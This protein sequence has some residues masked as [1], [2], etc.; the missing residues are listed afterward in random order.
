MTHVYPTLNHAK[1]NLNDI[2]KVILED[3]LP[4]EIGPVVV[5]F[6]GTGNV[7]KGAQE[8]FQCLPHEYI[9]PKDL[10]AFFESKSWDTRKL[11]GV[12]VDVADHVSCSDRNGDFDFS[13]YI[14]NPEKYTSYF[15]QT[16]APYIS[17]LVTGHYWDSACPRLLTSDQ[18]RKLAPSWKKNKRMITIADISCDIKV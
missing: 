2:G 7:S 17:M 8:I 10:K 4:K 18:A 16:L 9:K 6:T 15:Y 13:H 3:G 14:Q 5:A 12:V 1:R 11:Y